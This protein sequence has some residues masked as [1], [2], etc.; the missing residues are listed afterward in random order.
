ML[1]NTLS[2]PK[3]RFAVTIAVSSRTLFNMAY[4]RK[5]YEEEGME[6]YVAYQLEHENEPLKPGAAFPFV[7]VGPQ[8]SGAQPLKYGSVKTH[9]KHPETPCRA[10]K[11]QYSKTGQTTLH[12]TQ[13]QLFVKVTPCG[14]KPRT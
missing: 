12:S 13:N 3:P 10:N 1:L 9:T 6:K 8:R 4:E 2:Q 14:E 7:K 5:I 11:R